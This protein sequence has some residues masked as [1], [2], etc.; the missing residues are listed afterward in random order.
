[1]KTKTKAKQK[2]FE[3]KLDVIMNKSRVRATPI[4]RTPKQ[5]R[6]R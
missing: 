6:I 3:L 1:M 4:V 5:P 2:G